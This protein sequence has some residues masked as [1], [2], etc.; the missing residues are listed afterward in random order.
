MNVQL[1]DSSNAMQNRNKWGCL[2]L[3]VAGVAISW[4]VYECKYYYSKWSDYRNSP[5]A[6][7]EDEDAKLLVGKWEG[8]FSD[9]DKVRKNITLEVFVPL[10]DDER[11][12]KAGKR[13]KRRAFST[14]YNNN[15]DGI[16][17]VNSKLGTE[18]YKISGAVEKDDMHQLHFSFSPV[19]ERKKVVPNFTLLGA[20]QGKWD[21][22]QLT[23]TFN[24]GYNKADGA[25]YYNSADPRHEVKV[26]ATL[27]RKNK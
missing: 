3:L 16:A 24:F 25:S 8:S 20:T 17:T 14:R 22:D 27:R 1:Q 26:T 11:E 4:G 19:D 2:L 10:T 6:Y 18:E 12:N 21:N 13:W 7:S 15:F 5:W 9:P 23:V